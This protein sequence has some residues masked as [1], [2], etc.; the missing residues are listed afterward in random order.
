MRYSDTLV[1]ALILEAK[2]RG[3]AKA[4]ALLGTVLRDFLVEWSEDHI[5]APTMAIIPVPLSPERLRSRGY[6]QAERICAAALA[7]LP[8]ALSSGLL[9]RTRDTAPQTELSGDARR[10]NM[11]GAFAA[12]TLDPT[13]TYIVVD[14]VTTT[15]ATLHSCADTLTKGGA[16]KIVL[17]ALAR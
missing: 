1:K 6:N 8:H 12:G 13:H 4:T 16:V 17:L 10:K 9:T 7:G 2:F 3:S 5:D 11:E 14:D 15:G